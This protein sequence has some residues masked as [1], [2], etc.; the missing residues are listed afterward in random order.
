MSTYS[1]NYDFKRQCLNGRILCLLI[2]ADDRIFW[3]NRLRSGLCSRAKW[4][5]YY[6]FGLTDYGL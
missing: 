6:V 3:I 2:S 4:N 1:F 5:L